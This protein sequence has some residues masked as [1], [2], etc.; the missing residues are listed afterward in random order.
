MWLGALCCTDLLCCP[1]TCCGGKGGEPSGLSCTDPASL[2]AAP[3]AGWGESLVPAVVQAPNPLSLWPL[4]PGRDFLS[5]PLFLSLPRSRLS[6]RLFSAS[7][8]ARRPH[9]LLQLGG[10]C[11]SWNFEAQEVPG[12]VE[13]WGLEPGPDGILGSGMFHSHGGRWNTKAWKVP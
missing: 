3:R 2:H 12:S 8:R 6:L 13:H 1:E 10:V 5:L 7:P 9:S 11:G 4:P